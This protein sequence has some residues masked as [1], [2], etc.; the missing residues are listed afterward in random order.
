M[1]RKLTP[2]QGSALAV[3]AALLLGA[4]AVPETA[5]ADSGTGTVVKML[6]AC[7]STQRIVN[8]GANRVWD[9][10]GADPSDHAAIQMYDWN[11]GW[12]Q[13]WQLCPVGDGSG[14]QSIVS[15]AS[16]KC[17][18][19]T[20][21]SSADH[22]LLQLYPCNLGTN[23]QFR[24]INLN[25]YGYQVQAVNSAKCVDIAWADYSPG[26]QLQQYTCNAAA[27]NQRFSFQS[28]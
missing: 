18:D 13:K 23:Q 15:P 28:V 20:G 16:G 8:P 3:A 6:S 17:V 26:V 14:A 22:A 21:V 11:G 7:G 12:N 10:R 25:A 9:V 1:S 2:V 27:L 5:F 24:L 19:V 4:A